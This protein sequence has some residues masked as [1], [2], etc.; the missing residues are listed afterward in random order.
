MNDPSLQPD[1]IATSPG[2]RIFVGRNSVEHQACDFLPPESA[3]ST[4]KRLVTRHQDN[5]GSGLPSRPACAAAQYRRGRQAAYN[6]RNDAF[7]KTAA[8]TPSP[9][10]S[11]LDQIGLIQSSAKKNLVATFRETA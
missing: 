7:G 10:A 5:T 3:R 11:R 1:I 2:L 9:A 4:L 6:A 8:R